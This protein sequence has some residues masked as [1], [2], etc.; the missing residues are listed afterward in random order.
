MLITSTI[1]LS[2]WIIGWWGFI[3]RIFCLL[4]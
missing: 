3:Y 2:Y 1:L 4:P